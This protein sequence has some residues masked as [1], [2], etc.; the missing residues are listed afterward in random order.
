MP[1]GEELPAV[2]VGNLAAYAVASA[3]AWTSD[4]FAVGIPPLIGIVVAIVLALLVARR[5]APAPAEPVG[6][7]P[8]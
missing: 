3:L 4:H 6:S 1:E 2:H 8:R 7:V 5:T